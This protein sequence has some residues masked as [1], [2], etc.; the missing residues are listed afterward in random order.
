MDGNF[1]FPQVGTNPDSI[2][3]EPA[4]AGHLLT[5][6]EWPEDR[7]FP[8]GPDFPTITSP[9]SGICYFIGG[10]D[11][12][13]GGLEIIKIGFST[14]VHYRL[15]TLQSMAGPMR[16]ALLAGTYGGWAQERA[17]L[18]RFQEHKFSG[19]WFAPHPDILAEI[20]RLSAGAPQ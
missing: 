10:Y 3:N 12:K 9:L 20:E 11:R 2:A 4:S 14:K 1:T 16:L 8:L 17:Y 19:E 15:C 18:Q 13:S 5:S 6:P 7:P